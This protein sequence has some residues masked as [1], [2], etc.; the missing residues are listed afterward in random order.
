MRYRQQDIGHKYSEWC[1]MAYMGP[2]D[3]EGKPKGPLGPGEKAQVLIVGQNRQNSAHHCKIVTMDVETGDV[4][5]EVLPCPLIPTDIYGLS[6]VRVGKEIL[7]FGGY[8]NTNTHLNTLY[9]FDIETRVF[10]KVPQSGSWPGARRYHSAFFLGGCMIIAGG[11][12]PSPS[13]A[14]PVPSWNR[15]GRVALDPSTSSSPKDV[16]S[17][18]PSTRDW[19]QLDNMPSQMSL[20]AATV[21]GD[22]AHLIGS[23]I[24]NYQTH[25]TFTSS[26]GW[27]KK[28]NPGFQMSGGAALTLGSDILAISGN[29]HAD[30]VH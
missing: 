22:T 11:E 24:N 13:W 12:T 27:V 29:R 30:K 26:G 19:T 3:G 21:V 4:S 18:D 9:S 16:W 28:D 14:R 17:F 1:G 5:S 15:A 23:S 20:S 7:I 6:A 2:V 8:T 10:T 25:F